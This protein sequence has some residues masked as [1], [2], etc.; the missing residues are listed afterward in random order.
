MKLAYLKY[1]FWQKG[2]PVTFFIGFFFLIIVLLSFPVNTAFADVVVFDNVVP[3][4]KTI[5]L[6]ALTKGRFFTEGGKLVTFYVEGK[7]IGTTLSGGDGFAFFKYTPSSQGIIN[8]KVE[9]GDEGDEGV[10]LAAG[11]K[12]NIVIIEI[13]SILLENI[14]SRK[15]IK[16]SNESLKQLSENFR[17]LYI[18]TMIGARESRKWLKEKGFPVFPVFKWEGVEM[19]NELREQGIEVYAIIASPA[20]LSEA[21]D[22]NKRFSFNETEDATEVKDLPDFLNQLQS[23]GDK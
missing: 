3:V 14:F 22:I 23:N 13:E 2:Y 7:K 6:K 12:D 5:K 8:I 17:I 19:L 16:D 20:V 9:A 21:S 11:K 10:I 1:P 18:T 15:A 4:N